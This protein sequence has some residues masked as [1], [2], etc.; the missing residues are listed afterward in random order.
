[1]DHIDAAPTD[2][3]PPCMPAASVARPTAAQA[4]DVGSIPAPAWARIVTAQ[5]NGALGLA[6]PWQSLFGPLV[7]DRSAAL[8]IGQLGQSLDGRIATPQG[9]SHYINGRAAIEHLHRLRALVDAV[10]VGVG[11][12]RADDPLLTVRHVAG[13]SPAR[14]VL[15]PGGRL[16][17]GSRLLADDGCRRVVVTRPDAAW[18]PPAGVEHVALEADATGRMPPAA[19]VAALA[20][21]GLR[22]ILVEGGAFTVSRFLQAGC[23]DRLHL[24]VAPLIIGSGPTG[25][26]LDPIGRLDDALRPP[27][28]SYPLGDDLLLDVDLAALRTR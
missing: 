9:H 4:D 19:I 24:S 6:E 14:V 17:P 7:T 15:D 2:R 8:A 22:R 10:V 23:L 26:S 11:T 20:A 18:R 12:A 25:L 3:A 28:R 13:P 5:H 27:T 1:M 16:P 21:L